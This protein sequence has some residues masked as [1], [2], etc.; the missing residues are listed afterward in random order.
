MDLKLKVWELCMMMKLN[1]AIVCGIST[2]ELAQ[3]FVKQQ[4]GEV[5][6]NKVEAPGR[7]VGRFLFIRCVIS[8][9]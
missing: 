1:S 7:N 5:E 4:H 6:V 9:L 3:T 2:P 8:V